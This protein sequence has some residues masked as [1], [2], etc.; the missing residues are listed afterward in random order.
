MGWVGTVATVNPQPPL[1]S[2][3]SLLIIIILKSRCSDIILFIVP[4]KVG[5]PNFHVKICVPN[6]L[7][8]YLTKAKYGTKLQFGRI[9]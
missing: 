6:L 3:Q 9:V 8:V 5:T 1:S 7:S 4:R 2:R